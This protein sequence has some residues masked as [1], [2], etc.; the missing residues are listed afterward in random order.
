MPNFYDCTGRHVHLTL[1]VGSQAEVGILPAQTTLNLQLGEKSYLQEPTYP[2][3][4]E[5]A[6]HPHAL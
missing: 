2:D 1:V 3:H 5:H 6:V 4:G